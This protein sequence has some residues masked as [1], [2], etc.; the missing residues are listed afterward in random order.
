[1]GGVAGSKRNPWLQP[2]RLWAVYVNEVA[3]PSPKEAI[4]WMLLTTLEVNTYEQA[5][6]KIDWYNETWGMEEY[7][8][9][10]KSVCGIEDQPPTRRSHGLA[11]LPRR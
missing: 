6:E 9:T 8:K 1:M 3:P 10:L 4:E 5:V 7:D 11:E 2:L